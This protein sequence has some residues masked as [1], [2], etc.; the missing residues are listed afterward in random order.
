MSGALEGL[1]VVDLT[2]V[3]MGPWAAQMMGDMGAD[4]I[5]VET[6]QGDISR[7]MGPARNKGMAACYLTTNR[8]K[9]S[10]V[11]DLT[12]PE[13]LRALRKL[14]DSAD[15]FMHNFRPKVMKKFD[16]GYETFKDTN[17]ELVYCGAYGFRADGP[18]ADKP[19][20]DDIIQTAAGVCEMQTIVSDQPRFV[21]T[22][23][24]DK[25][26]AYAVFSAILAA[27]VHRERGG[28]GQAVEVPMF[29]TMVDF[30]MVEHLYGATFDPPIAQM[31]YERL[32]NT[33]R[34]PYATLDGY[35][36]VLPYTDKNWAD[37]F[38]IVGREELS[39]DA[40]FGSHSERVRNSETVYGFLAEIVATR[41]TADWVRAL[42]DANIP[43][44]V[45]QSKEDLLEHEQ[46][47][48]T[49]FWH[50]VE[51][52][53]EGRLKLT[54][55][56][57]RFSKSPSSIRTMPPTLGQQSQ[58]ILSEAGF[59]ADEIDELIAAKITVRGG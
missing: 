14:I 32:L 3:I 53:T 39:E 9:R 55:P 22:L 26:C 52:P 5:K 42:D 59:S 50:S 11:L 57:L 31:G 45:V 34:R 16:L 18:M 1:R 8:N 38:K 4:V 35:L 19:A 41:T 43:V 49:G 12:Q 30:V 10:V 24:A 28:G 27:V 15:V 56:P 37:F 46:L 40:I 7:G 21:P 17:P 2:T 48:A 13:G 25:T 23:M 29:E 44:M 6:R 36:T 47:R 33:E 20:Y 58:E 51:H 54:D